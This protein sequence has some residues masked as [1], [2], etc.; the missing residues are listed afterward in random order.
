[1][2]KKDYSVTEDLAVL[3]DTTTGMTRL[4]AVQ[5]DGSTKKTLA[6]MRERYNT[7]TGTVKNNVFFMDLITANAL[8]NALC[9]YFEEN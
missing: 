3:R 5:F 9:N 6:I 7:G 1:M 2:S 8:K 4:C